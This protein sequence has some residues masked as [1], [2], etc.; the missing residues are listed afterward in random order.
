MRT[1]KVLA[2]IACIEEKKHGFHLEVI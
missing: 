2:L 1:A